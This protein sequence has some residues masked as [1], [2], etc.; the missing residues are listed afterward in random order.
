MSLGG[1]RVR[2]LL[3]S[4]DPD[5]AAQAV[6]LA[7]ALGEP[8]LFSELLRGCQLTEGTLRGNNLFPGGDWKTRMS[9]VSLSSLLAL[10]AHAPAAARIHPSLR[11]EAVCVLRVEV[12]RDLDFPDAVSRLRSLHRL[13]LRGN[14]L[15]ELPESITRFPGLLSLELAQN[16]LV[17]LPEPVTR[18]A[19]LRSL[20]LSFNPLAALHGAIGRLAALE[21]LSL[22]SCELTEL[23]EGMRQLERLVSLNLSRARRLRCLPPVVYALPALRH[24][25]LRSSRIRLSIA[26]VARLESLET[27]E[28]NRGLYRDPAGIRAELRRLRPG[29]TTNL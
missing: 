7:A 18:L 5:A 20:D 15:A 25:S 14:A 28:L 19:T 1:A 6:E 21:H 26:D 3:E 29:L 8:E 17:G 11:R 16:R 12:R 13:N 4:R 2:E 27:L 22:V 10:I 24:L 23:P 9:A